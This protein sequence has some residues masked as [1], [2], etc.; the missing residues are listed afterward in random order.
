MNDDSRGDV[1]IEILLSAGRFEPA[2]VTSDTH[3][4][5]GCLGPQCS[6]AHHGP[7]DHTEAFSTASFESERPLSLEALREAARTFPAGVYR[8]KGIV[9]SP[10]APGRRVVLQVVGKRVELSVGEDWGDQPPR[11]RIMAIG[12]PGTVS[13]HDLR[14]RLQPCI[15][16]AEQN[17]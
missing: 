5:D 8:A 4:H 12:A 3:R 1:P 13:E 16:A 9:H 17:A 7:T 15:L 14:M 11:T 6:H 10:E 2:H